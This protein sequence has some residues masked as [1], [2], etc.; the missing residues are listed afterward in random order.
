MIKKRF[1]FGLLAIMLA[2]GTTIISCDIIGTQS[3]DSAG[4]VNTPNN[5]GEPNNNEPTNTTY[6]NVTFNIINATSGNAPNAQTVTS[7]SII[8]LPD[9]TGFARN[10]YTFNGWNTSPNGLGSNYIIGYSYIVTGNVVLYA[11][12]EIAKFTVTF[13]INEATSGVAPNDQSSNY[14]SYIILP[15]N[16]DFSKTGAVFSGWTTDID[17]LNQKYNAGQNYLI[18]ENITLYARWLYPANVYGTFSTGNR[19]FFFHG[20]G[21][22]THTLG[23]DSQQGTYS[24]TIN[25]TSEI[26]TI[27]VYLQTVV[28]PN[29][30]T[31]H[32]GSTVMTVINAST[33]NSS[34]G[35][36]YKY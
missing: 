23:N 3:D 19:S 22:L 1:L 14:L 36:L 21:T 31:F 9:G 28:L 35:V 30:N 7:N 12:W 13:D 10:G 26:S 16:S 20:N 11:K 34:F 4:E 8:I 6:Y 2:F 25:P 17:G 24:V 27:N 15:D 29:G 18:T 32:G 33:I 5:N